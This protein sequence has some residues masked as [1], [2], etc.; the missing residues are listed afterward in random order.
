[1]KKKLIFI[2]LPLLLLGGGAGAW[3][4]LFSAPAEEAAGAAAEETPAAGDGHAA[5]PKAV[6]VE[7]GEIIV[8]VYNRDGKDNFMVVRLALEL[9]DALTPEQVRQ[10]MPR[11]LDAYVNTLGTMA[12]RGEFAGSR[13]NAVIK[14]ALKVA[15]DRIL[16][17]D[18][19]A[20]V[21]LQ[22]AWQQ[23]M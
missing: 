15:T 1:V 2:L 4:F 22:R 17:P 13:R 3:F 14:R 20:D 23:P 9:G 6:F 10:M 19:V 8:P 18:A 16:G 21:L 12:G 11:L 7:I 5:A